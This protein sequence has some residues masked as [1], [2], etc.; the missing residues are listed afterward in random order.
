MVA[1]SVLLLLLLIPASLRGQ[2]TDIQAF[3]DLFRADPF[4]RL[5]VAMDDALLVCGLE[6]RGHGCRDLQRLVYGQ[7]LLPVDPVPERLPLD[8]RH[9]LEQEAA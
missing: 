8:L 9:Q 1:R 3:L 5:D 7:F 2:A 6:G 4:A